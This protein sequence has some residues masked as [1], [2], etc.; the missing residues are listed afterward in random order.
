[1]TDT[2]TAALVSRGLRCHCPACDGSY[3]L[4]D[5]MG[6]RFIQSVTDAILREYG[7]PI[8]F[9]C[10]NDFVEPDDD[11]AIADALAEARDNLRMMVGY[12]A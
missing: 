6:D 10:A 7:A 4:G 5:M 11:D 3:H 1:M 12:R 8:C 9:D 2:L